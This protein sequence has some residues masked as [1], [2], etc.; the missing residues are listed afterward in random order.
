MN[1]FHQDGQGACLCCSGRTT[2]I[3]FKSFTTGLNQPDWCEPMETQSTRIS[4]P[5]PDTPQSAETLTVSSCHP[6]VLRGHQHPEPLGSHR[7]SIT[8]E[9]STRYFKQDGRGEGAPGLAVS[10]FSWSKPVLTSRSH[11]R[12]YIF[13]LT[14]S[15]VSPWCLCDRM[16]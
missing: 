10:S 13:S 3:Q 15:Q 9:T 12:F 1:L 8:V 14:H 7:E 11:S 2:F 16:E 5:K 6:R 4:T